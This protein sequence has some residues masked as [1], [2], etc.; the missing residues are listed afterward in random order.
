M[1]TSATGT[2]GHRKTLPGVQGAEPEPKPKKK[3]S[4]RPL[5]GKKFAN[6][7]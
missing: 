2:V 7:N 5:M 3:K 6:I 4:K 1:A